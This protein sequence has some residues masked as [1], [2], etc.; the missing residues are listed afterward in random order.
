MT[1]TKRMIETIEIYKKNSQFTTAEKFTAVYKNKRKYKG[2]RNCT[3][4]P[5]T[6]TT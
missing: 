4:C 5:V 1:E 2:V 3:K 6:I